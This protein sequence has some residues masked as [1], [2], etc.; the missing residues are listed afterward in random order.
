[1]IFKSDSF[2]SWWSSLSPTN[3]SIFVLYPFFPCSLSLISFSSSLISGHGN[4][5]H[6]LLRSTEMQISVWYTENW[7]QFQL[8]YSRIVNYYYCCYFRKQLIY[9]TNELE[10]ILECTSHA[11]NN[12]LLNWLFMKTTCSKFCSTS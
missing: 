8:I 10:V 9:W 2:G 12:Y 5:H 1:M 6:H 7:K 3:S 11:L 4:Q